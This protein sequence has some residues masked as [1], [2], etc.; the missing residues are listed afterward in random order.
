M[1]EIFED[2]DHPSF[3]S[4]YWLPSSLIFNQWLEENDESKLEDPVEKIEE[5]NNIAKVNEK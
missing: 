4:E 1:A 5:E 3:G 2:I